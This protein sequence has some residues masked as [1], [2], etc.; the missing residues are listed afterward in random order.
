MPVMPKKSNVCAIS[1]LS[2]VLVVLSSSTRRS[3]CD[4]FGS[5]LE[6]IPQMFCFW[7]IY[8]GKDMKAISWGLIY[9][10]NAIEVDRIVLFDTTYIR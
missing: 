10:F 1:M 4:C 2:S 3:F 6:L 5:S 7:A 9:C 8:E